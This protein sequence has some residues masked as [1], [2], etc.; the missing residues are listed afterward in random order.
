LNI[1]SDTP[2]ET[3]TAND[4]RIHVKREDL[5]CPYPGPS[6]SKIRGLFA[7]I[8]TKLNSSLYPPD[9][10]GVVDSIHSK[11]GWG[12]AYL[13]HDLNIP[14]MVFYPYT[15]AQGIDKIGYFQFRCLDLGASIYPIPATKSAVLWYKARK[16]FKD[17]HPTGLLLPNGLKLQETVNQTC[18]ELVNDA[19]AVHL[20][21]NPES[22]WIISISS[23]TIA[24]GVIK[25]LA[26][27]L[28]KGTIILHMGY[29]RSRDGLRHYLSKMDCNYANVR[30]Q[31]IDEG[32]GYSDLVQCKSPFPCNP[33]YD[34]KAWKWL[35]E[36]IDILPKNIV[37]WN[38]GA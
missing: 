10:I 21:S 38:I 7:Y 18:E 23:G 1:V 3:Y 27:L 15:K 34:L 2:W 25:G 30:I 20:A 11:A 8:N 33:Y 36:H 9:C 28:Y 5:C 13:C 12:T 35:Q 17:G 22:C 37:F 24:A 32:Y 16:I 31:I 29:S 14:C 19:L 6:F 4:T 26:K